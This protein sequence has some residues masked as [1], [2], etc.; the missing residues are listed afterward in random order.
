MTPATG[1][2]TDCHAHIIDPVRFPL[3]AGGG[4]KPREDEH[5]TCGAYCDVLDRHGMKNGLLVQL[6]GYGTDNRPLLDAIAA[7]PD[8][9][10]AIGVVDSGFTDRQLEDLARGGIVGVRFNLPSYDAQALLRPD[11]P[12]LLARIK[13][14]GWFAQ[15][16]ADDQQWQEAAPI[17][18]AS[19]V[20]VLIDHFGVR[21]IAG[22]LGQKGF[23]AVLAL[24]RE[25]QAV[26]KFSSLFRVSLRM[27]DYA[28][29]DPFVARLVPAFTLDRIVW[30]SDWPFINVPKRPTYAEV[31]APLDRWFPDPAD[32]ARVLARNPQR[33]FGFKD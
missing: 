15:V 5:G 32:K 11:A 23:G 27:G 4:Y 26:V 20:K 31:A 17:L 19:G 16:Y 18:K 33:L 14:L 9:F 13:A 22:G 30:G 25:G 7:Y 29:L 28:D 1:T 12:R 10:K 3:P 21:D 2:N 8:R 24:G 6:S